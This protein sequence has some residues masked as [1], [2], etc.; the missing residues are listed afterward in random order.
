MDIVRDL[1]IVIN[2]N[3]IRIARGIDSFISYGR[4]ACCFRNLSNRLVKLRCK[5]MGCIDDETDVMLL[6]KRTHRLLIKGTIQTNAVMQGNILLTCLGAV[7]IG[8]ASL[9]QHFHS[10][11]AF[12]RSSKYE[13]NPRY[14]DFPRAKVN[15]FL[16]NN[17]DNSQKV[18]TL[19]RKQQTLKE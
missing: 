1:V 6:T 3:D 18:V 13:Y 17:K 4:D 9:F 5:G 2:P 11:T 16:L 12:R 8:I 15:N 7:I 14:H 10:L 19:Q